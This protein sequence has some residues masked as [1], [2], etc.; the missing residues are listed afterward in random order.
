MPTRIEAD[1]IDCL[2][3]INNAATNVVT[4]NEF[5]LPPWCLATTE[6]TPPSRCTVFYSVLGDLSRRCILKTA[7]HF[8]RVI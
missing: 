6:R 3:Y 1:G 2:L 5:S 4:T 7:S 8:R